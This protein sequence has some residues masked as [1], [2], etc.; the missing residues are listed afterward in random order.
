MI[1]VVEEFAG[2]LP[3]GGTVADL[4]CGTGQH[5]VALGLRGVNVIAVDYAPAIL[6]RARTH[7]L[8]GRLVF[9][10]QAMDRLVEQSQPGLR[11]RRRPA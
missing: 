1:A 11:E 5:A 6:A 9:L 8:T 4:G 3:P 10:E 7:A 2:P